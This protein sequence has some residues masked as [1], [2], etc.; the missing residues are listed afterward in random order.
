VS[1]DGIPLHV[2]V[3]HLAVVLTPLTCVAAL[4]WATVPQWRP[5]LQSPLVIGVVA[6]LA[7]VWTAFYSGPDYWLQP[8]FSHAPSAQIH[9]FE[10]HERDAGLLL[11]SAS[12]F[13]LAILIAVERSE[14]RT[15]A[16]LRWV[17]AGAALVTLALV[18]IT[19]HA[20]AKAVWAP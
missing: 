2:L 10:Q 14:G 13:A 7:A 3:V 18:V 6:S 20:G 8:Q 1:F 15:G 12:A 5:A 17:A 11:W 19:G 16:A 4:A 9:L